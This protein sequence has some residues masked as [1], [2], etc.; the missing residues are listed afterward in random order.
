MKKRILIALSLA[1]LLTFS[2]SSAVFAADPTE[3]NVTWDGAG[4]VDG[5]VVAGDDAT[6]YFHSEGSSHSGT[7]HATDSNNNPYSYGVDSCSFSLDTSIVGGGWAGLDVF[8][9]DAK[10]S[11]G[12][13]GQ[14]SFT[15]VWT[16]DGDATLQ[17]RSGTNYASMG[18]HNY[19]WNSSNHITV[20]NA[21]AYT[22][23]RF[24]SS[25]PTAGV[26]NFAGIRVDGGSGD[27]NLDCMSSSAS[28][29]Q[30]RL[31]WGGGC[32]TNAGFTATGTGTLTLNAF[33]NNS[34]TTAMAPGM[35]GATSFQIIASWVGSFSI[36]DYSTTA[37]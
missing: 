36:A 15:Y 19:G 13:A 29:G 10:T 27:A 12:V 2:F 1:L 30:I 34:T 8:R 4:V 23:Q 16:D 9:T 35:I 21:S 33:G 11:Y 26:A 5:T 20:T 22:L 6:A 28:A 32:Y 14:R 18:D 3:V 7:F 31:G 17:N 25:T 24:M 37:N